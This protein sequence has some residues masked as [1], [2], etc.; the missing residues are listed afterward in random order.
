MIYRSPVP[1]PEIPDLAISPYVLHR[2]AELGDRPAFVDAASGRSVSYLQL[3]FGTAMAAGGWRALGLQR[4][5]VVAIYLPN[6]PEYPAIFHSIALAGGVSALLSPLLVGEALVEQVRA[7]RARFIVSA[8]PLAAEAA[9]TG[10][11]LIGVGDTPGARPFLSLLAEPTQQVEVDPATD[12][13]ALTLSSGTEG[14]PKPVMITHRNLVAGVAQIEALGQFSEADTFLGLLPFT[15]VYGA[16]V[17]MLLPTRIGAKVATLMRFELSGFLSA[18][19][20]H[21]VTVAHLVPP[22]VH[23]LARHPGVG[24]HDLSALRGVISGAAPL[25]VELGRACADRLG[26]YVVDGY[27]LSEALATHVVHDFEGGRHLGTVGEPLPCCACRIVD[28]LTGLDVPPGE[29]G[30]ILVRGPTVTRGYLDR[31]E[32]S[33]RL[34]DADGWLHSGDLGRVDEL[35]RLHVVDRLKELIKVGGAA[36]APATLEQALRAHPAV[37]DAAVI[38]AP[39]AFLG[40]VPHAFVAL[41]QPIE[42]DQ[43]AEWLHARVPADHRPRAYTVLVAIPRSPAGKIL[44]RQLRAQLATTLTG[45]EAT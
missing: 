20:E 25:P 15:H 11:E 18:L 44:R 42:L 33:A 4:G 40:E 32:E 8:G 13:A 5:E 27:G 41:V 43:L 26:C 17:G 34:I 38:G 21:R 14:L 28:P 1:P 45:S 30:E 39:D 6:I 24:E 7:V 12:L 29:V 22:L 19:S 2:A 3:A 16:T 10:L 35:G 31:P 36:V 37:A 9:R 23:A